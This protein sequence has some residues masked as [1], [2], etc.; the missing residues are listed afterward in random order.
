MKKEIKNVVKR[1]ELVNKK[2]SKGKEYRVIEVELTN[3]Y[4]ESVFLT[5][6]LNQLIDI[7]S[8]E[9]PEDAIS[10]FEIVDRVSSNGVPYR[11]CN[12]VLTDGYDEALF[13]PR[14]LNKLIDILRKK[15]N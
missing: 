12:V 7:Y 2:T 13:L 6:S 9:K 5:Q 8:P 10:K 11:V 3:S 14:A 4:K 1:I 15:E